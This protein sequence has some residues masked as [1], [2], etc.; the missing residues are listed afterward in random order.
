MLSS[1]ENPRAEGLAAAQIAGDL[2]LPARLARR[3]SAS[4]IE[5]DARLFGAKLHNDRKQISPAA[6]AVSPSGETA[7]PVRSCIEQLAYSVVS[8]SASS[9]SLP[10]QLLTRF[11]QPFGGGN[12]QRAQHDK[13]YAAIDLAH[14]LLLPN[15]VN[16]PVVGPRFA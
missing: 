15:L 13:A 11:H 4:L 6:F 10:L 5:T 12:F 1:L 3:P 2:R 8:V 16:R 7:D 9:V 14:P